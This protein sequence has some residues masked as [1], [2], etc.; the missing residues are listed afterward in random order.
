M[1]AT[2]SEITAFLMWNVEQAAFLNPNSENPLKTA[3]IL[4]V[5]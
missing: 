3:F 4:S 2:G 5:H 1:S